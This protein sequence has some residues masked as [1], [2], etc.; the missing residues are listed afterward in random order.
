MMGE[1]LIDECFFFFFFE[2][3]VFFMRNNLAIPCWIGF[4]ENVILFV[5]LL[6]VILNNIQDNI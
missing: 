5:T 2:I 1:Y 3:M 6:F 4:I